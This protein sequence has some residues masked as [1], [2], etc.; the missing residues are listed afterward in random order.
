MP[1]YW[2]VKTEPSSYSYDD[3]ERE[4]TAVWDG[5]KNPVAIRNLKSMH[6]GDQVLV[7]H[8]GDEKA[9]VGW[10]TVVSA[11][12]PDPKAQEENLVAIDFKAHR[13][14]PTP[15]TLAQLKADKTFADLPIIKQGRLSVSPVTAPQW[16][17][18]LQLAGA[19]D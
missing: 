5:V 6:P 8:T 9:V 12:Y 17:R 14:L 1:N 15:V 3:L 7:Y 13:R 10:A 11:P 18:V 19:N 16:K 2:L 4:K